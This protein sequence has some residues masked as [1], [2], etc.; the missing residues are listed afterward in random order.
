MVQHRTAQI[1]I[2]IPVDISL[3]MLYML[4]VAVITSCEVMLTSVI[5]YNFCYHFLPL[6]VL[7]KHLTHLYIN[8]SVACNVSNDPKYKLKPFMYA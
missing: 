3:Y 6:E 1:L 7:L 8:P 4:E 2:P 5:C